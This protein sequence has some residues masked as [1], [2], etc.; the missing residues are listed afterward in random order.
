MKVIQLA[1]IVIVS[2]FS[3]SCSSEEISDAPFSKQKWYPE[4]LSELEKGLD[5]YFDMPSLKRGG[6]LPEH[7]FFVGNWK[8][9]DYYDREARSEDLDSCILSSIDLY[10]NYFAC[11]AFQNVSINSFWVDR[12]FGRWMIDGSTLKLKIYSMI[13][14]RNR[15]SRSAEKYENTIV[16]IQPHEIVIASINSIDSTGY[17]KTRISGIKLPLIWGKRPEIPEK[18][19]KPFI[20]RSRGESLFN[21]H[22]VFNM[23]IMYK[24]MLEDG[25]SVDL[26]LKDEKYLLEMY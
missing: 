4:Y 18:H 1:C 19:Y 13:L 7:E 25:G 9:Y 2:F 24:K 11:I 10:P 21:E 12:G 20:F 22:V 6:L 17:I 8:V 16:N 3:F 26:L 23:P 14:K 15:A 5:Q